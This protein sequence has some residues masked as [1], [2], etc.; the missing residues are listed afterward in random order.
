M[1]NEVVENCKDSRIETPAKDVEV[2]GPDGASAYATLV[3]RYS[4]VILLD[5][6]AAEDFQ[7]EFGASWHT[8]SGWR[9]FSVG[10]CTARDVSDALHEE[11]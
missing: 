1:L 7:D 11:E 9:V 8:I 3:W 5:E 10:A 6:E 4:K 2:F